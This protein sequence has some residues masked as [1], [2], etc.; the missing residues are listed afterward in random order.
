M[1]DEPLR[2]VE[3]I[4]AVLMTDDVVAGL[5]DAEQ[6][7]AIER[8]FARLADPDFEVQ[9]VGPKGSPPQ[10]FGLGGS[11]SGGFTRVW[12]EWTSAFESFRI[13]IEEQIPVGERVI[14]LVVLSGRTKTGGVEISQPAA[15][16]WTVRNGKLTRAEFHLDRERALRSAGLDPQSR[17]E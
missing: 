14:S 1:S 3:E 7:G 15:A 5:E 8:T 6:G 9:M 11:G 17:Q 16:V 12:E 10:G 4:Q 2:V 13:E